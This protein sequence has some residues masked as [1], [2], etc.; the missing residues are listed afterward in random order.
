[1]TKRIPSL[2]GLRAFSIVL[3]LIGHLGGTAGFDVPVPL[4][5]WVPSAHFG[6]RV[7]FVISG[8]LITSLLLEESKKTGTIDVLKFYFRRA[9]RIFPAFYAFVLVMALLSSV[10]LVPLESGDL[11]HAVTYTTNYN[12]DRAWTLGHL[13]SLSVEEQFY[14]L[15]PFVL[16]VAGITRGKWFALAY[17]LLAPF[18]RVGMWKFFPEMRA[19]IGETFE[20]AADAIAVGCLLAYHRDWLSRQAWLS[21]LHRPW[22]MAGIVGLAYLADHF[23]GYVSI[24]YTVGE[25]YMNV[26]I[27]LAIDWSVRHARGRIGRLLNSPVLVFIGQLSYSLYLW[28]QPF[29]DDKSPHAWTHF[30]MNLLLAITCGVISYYVIESPTLRW[31]SKVEAWLW[32]NKGRPTPSSGLGVEHG[33]VHREAVVERG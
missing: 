12:S 1:M 2:D 3:V 9:F 28:Q 29:M 25:T 14:L 21:V 20:T 26:A 10:E 5:E 4:L 24:S 16:L 30:P 23:Y 18:V 8:F 13:W 22:V 6:V 31:R 15:W 19:G 11:L 17:V 27:A 32:P 33:V 7:F